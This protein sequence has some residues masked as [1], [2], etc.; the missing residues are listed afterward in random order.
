MKSRS[1]KLVDCITKVATAHG[2]TVHFV[3]RGDKFCEDNGE[4]SYVEHSYIAGKEIFLGFY[5]DE[6][7][8]LISAFHEIGHRIIPRWSWKEYQS[9]LLLELDCWR[10]GILEARKFDVLF[11]DKAIEWGYRQALSYVGRDEREMKEWFEKH[12]VNL[13]RNKEADVSA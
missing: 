7:L 9:T 1:K 11:S 6:E 4:N 8:E 10:L 12:R 2:L 13:W 3:E 5:E